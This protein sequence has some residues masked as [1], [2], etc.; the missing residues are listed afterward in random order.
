M[1]DS[2]LSCILIYEQS[3]EKAWC[4]SWKDM[5]VLFLNQ[6]LHDF[7]SF[8]LIVFISK[9]KFLESIIMLH[10]ISMRSVII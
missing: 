3:T 4:V 9:E 2:Q 1:H 6:A 8:L 10:K 7:S 5:F